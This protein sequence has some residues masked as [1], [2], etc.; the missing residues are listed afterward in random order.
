[1]GTCAM[2]YSNFI[3]K[4]EFIPLNTGFDPEGLNDHLKDFQ[5]A[6]VNWAIRRGK[7][8]IFA[9]TGL[10]KTIMQCEWARLVAEHTNKPV[11]IFAPLAVAEQTISEAVKFDIADIKYIRSSSE[12]DGHNIYISNYEMQHEIDPDIFSGVV[13]DESSI[14]KNQTGRIRTEMIDRWGSVD[15]RLSC[16]ATPSPNDFKELGNQ[17]EFLGIM[18]TVEMLAM[19]FVNDTGNTGTWR[20]KGH[21]E[22]KFYEWMATWAV[23]I[24]MP[25]DIGFSDDGYIL[26]PLNIVEHEIEMAEPM[27]GQLFAMPAQSLT[28]RRAAKRESINHR[29]ELAAKL[30]NDSDESWI[31][32]CHLNDEQDALEKSINRE[33]VSVRGADKIEHKV[34]GL[35]GFSSGKYKNIVSKPSIAGFGMNWQHSHNMVFTGMDDSF[36]KF[37]QAVRRQYRFG[38]TKPVNVH[39]IY[40]DAEGNV[41]ANIERKQKQHEELSRNMVGCMREIMQKEISGATINKTEY[42]P[43]VKMETPLWM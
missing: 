43:Q 18:S 38:Q 33:V 16:T 5:H 15:Y 19:F 42:N 11:I 12:I 36:E 17:A 14:L 35:S 21:G 34:D 13:L 39:I 20:L 40:S 8:A 10:G 28:E 27:D 2:S 25:S 6:I 9:D 22:K 7:A 41:K 4:K 29:V 23:V 26:P 32:W 37:Y 24:R 3:Q 1:M 30:I 31:A